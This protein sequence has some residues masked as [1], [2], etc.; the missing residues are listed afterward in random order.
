VIARVAS[1]LEGM[2]EEQREPALRV[3]AAL[4]DLLRADVA[5]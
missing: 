1:A 4:D 5:F 2:D 3:L